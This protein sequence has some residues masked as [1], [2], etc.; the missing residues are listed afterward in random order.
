MHHG[1][2]K[3]QAAK[4]AYNTLERKK[5]LVKWVGT[6]KKFVDKIGL[7]LFCDGVSIWLAQLSFNKAVAQ[8]R[9]EK[10]VI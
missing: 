10:Q 5:Q 2:K 9:F 8:W 1:R 7:L 6:L 4:C 3:K